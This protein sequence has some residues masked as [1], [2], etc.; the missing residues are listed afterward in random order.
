MN[1]NPR[2]LYDKISKNIKKYRKNSNITQA[3]LA[4]R[5]GVSHEFIRRIESEKGKKTFSVDTLYKISLA[6]DIPIQ[7]LFD[8]N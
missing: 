6:L 3:V 7:K 2:D 8:E 5:V 4:E 1:D